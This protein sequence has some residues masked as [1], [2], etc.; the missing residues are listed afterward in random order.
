MRPVLFEYLGVAFYS[1]GLLWFMGVLG[2]WLYLTS[3]DGLLPRV[4]ERHDAAK[5][6]LLTVLGAVAGAKLVHLGLTLDLDSGLAW[7]QQRP[8]RGFSALGALAGG[9]VGVGLGCRLL[10]LSLLTTLDRLT[11]AACFTV[12]VGRVGCLMAGC[13]HGRPS[14]SWLAVTFDD[15]RSSAPLG[16]ALLPSQQLAALAALVVGYGLHLRLLRG[17][18]PG[19]VFFLALTLLAP[20][21]TALQ[22][23]RGDMEVP[24]P[25]E[26]LFPLLSLAGLFL[27][28]RSLRRPPQAPRPGR[29]SLD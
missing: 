8:G 29:A 14:E 23:V 18:P 24:G 15:P 25:A 9:L 19:E 11:P 28:V 10:D 16:V 12:A 7:G 5:V 17:R 4:G 6:Y 1:Y 3:T 26:P 21:Q 27:L 2:A 22:S 20:I 13:C